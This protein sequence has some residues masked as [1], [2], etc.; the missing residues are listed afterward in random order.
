MGKFFKDGVHG[1]VFYGSR[2][3][4]TALQPKKRGELLSELLNM[5]EYDKIE[6]CMNNS[7]RDVIK[8][9]L[10]IESRQRYGVLLKELRDVNILTM[11]NQDKYIINPSL[12]W[13][14][15]IK[16]REKAIGKYDEIR[17]IAEKKARRIR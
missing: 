5:L 9:K 15:S 11:V 10:K 6:I 3:F 7:K 16:N 14:G 17:R 2:E 8:R 4:V 1:G 12:I 13:H